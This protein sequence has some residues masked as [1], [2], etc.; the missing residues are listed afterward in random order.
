MKNKIDLV[1]FCALTTCS[2]LACAN[3]TTPYQ[4]FIPKN[5][6]VLSQA[7]GDLN[8]D[9]QTD[10]ALIIENTD[11]KNIVTNDRLG[12]PQLNLNQ[13][14]LLILLKSPQGYRLAASNSTLPSEGDQE[15]PCLADPLGE[16]NPLTI[17]NGLV[18]INLHYWLSCGS[19]YVSNHVFTFRY[20]NQSFQLIGYDV[21][22][23]HRTSGE[24]NAKSI[25]FLTGKIKKTTGGSGFE[26][27]KQTAQESWS[28]L[29]QK[30][31]L[32]LERI[33]FKNYGE[34]E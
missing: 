11:P 15:S 23:F 13:R 7:Q 1:L 6:K 18:Q 19:W 20:Q 33:D 3:N 8:G 17:K 25:N 30:Y 28:K 12:N 21:N 34:Y 2:T 29:K 32:T 5:W 24:T 26:N 14:K 16:G 27:Q 22:D 10:V 9:R 31:A 4:S